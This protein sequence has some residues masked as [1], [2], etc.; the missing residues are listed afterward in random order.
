MNYLA[1]NC[2]LGNLCTGKELNDVIQE[3]YPFIVFI[4][5]TWTYEARL[6]LVQRNIDFDHKWVV[7][8]EGRGGDLVHFWKSIVNLRVVDSN[9]YLID[10]FINENSNNE[11]RFTGFYGDPD[12]ARRIDARN[13]L[14]RLNTW[15]SIPLLCVGDCNELTKPKEKLGGAP[16]PHN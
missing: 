11:W 2:R 7:P 15:P 3:K 9:K 12:I 8:K 6:N 4:V 5:E 13:E 10:A 1:W 14:R 16:C